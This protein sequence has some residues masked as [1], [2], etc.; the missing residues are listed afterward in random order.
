[1]RT[2]L[3]LGA[4]ASIFASQ[5]TTDVL[6]KTLLSKTELDPTVRNLLSNNAASFPD[7]EQVYASIDE[8]INFKKSYICKISRQLQRQIPHSPLTEY[9]V[10]LDKLITLKP[11]IREIIL[12][13]FKLTQE[14]INEGN[15]LFA[16]LEELIAGNGD[17]K[18]QIITTN[19]DLIIYEYADSQGREVVDGF[20]INHPHS[21]RATWDGAWN[22]TT[23][24]P[25]Y[26]NK[27]HGSVNWQ[28][29]NDEGK[30]IIR[31]S[32]PGHRSEDLDVMIA[33]TLGEKNYKKTPFSELTERFKNTLEE[34][35]V[36]IVIGSSFRDD[37]LNKIIKDKLADKRL[38][39]I[40]IS[41]D[42]HDHIKRLIEDPIILDV[43]NLRVLR[44]SLSHGIVPPPFPK[45]YRHVYS[46]ES[47]FEL[48]TIDEIC[49]V[50]NS[51]FEYETRL[52]RK[53]SRRTIS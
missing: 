39:I 22:N 11:I 26:L 45:H 41:P 3:F 1:M 17:D 31:I 9:D 52:L 32:D 37:E 6:L 23:D 43:P 42:S 35:D 8:A 29:Q 48:N 44:H 24:N 14:K 27:L 4:G 34:I 28:M 30:T 25:I 18:F 49:N 19:Y 12:D 40:S 51:I 15:L 47:K 21:L 33:P 2:A 36:L 53:L 7:I 5:P 46:Y 20:S 13:S 50:L 38:V 16:R 10:I